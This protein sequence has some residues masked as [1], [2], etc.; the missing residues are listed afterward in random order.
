MDKKIEG[1]D[2]HSE[3]LKMKIVSYEGRLTFIKVKFKSKY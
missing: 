2:Y 3:M 1:S